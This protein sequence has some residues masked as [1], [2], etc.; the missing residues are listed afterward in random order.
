MTSKF[1]QVMLG[2][3]K[4][5]EYGTPLDFFDKLDSIFHFKYDPCAFPDNRLGVELYTDKQHNGLDKEWLWNTFINPPFGTKK[6][7]Q[8]VDW[9]RKMKEESDKYRNNKYIM[10]LPTRIESNWFQEEIFKDYEGIIYVLRGRLRFYNPKTNKNNDP[11]PMGS[12]LYIRDYNM[13]T[14]N[15]HDLMKLLPGMFIERRRI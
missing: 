14:D 12:V 9:I 13:T 11:H 3:R 4:T 8:V 5:S 10:L 7:E 15:A 6:G 2:A 1:S